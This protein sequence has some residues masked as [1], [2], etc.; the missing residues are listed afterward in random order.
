MRARAGIVSAW[1]VAGVLVLGLAVAIGNYLNAADVPSQPLEE[2]VSIT[3]S[4]IVYKEDEPVYE[5]EYRLTNTQDRTAVYRVTFGFQNTTRTVSRTVGAGQTVTGVIALPPPLPALS[6]DGTA[7]PI[8]VLNVTD[9][10]S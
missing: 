3:S 8:E 4:G 5:A 10:S 6:V 2:A 7:Q 1:L 9:I